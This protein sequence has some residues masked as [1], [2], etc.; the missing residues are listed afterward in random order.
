LREKEAKRLNKNRII[1]RKGKDLFVL[2]TKYKPTEKNLENV[3]KCSWWKEDFVLMNNK[4]ISEIAEY[5]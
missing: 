1:Y 5:V 2:P 4:P 3:I